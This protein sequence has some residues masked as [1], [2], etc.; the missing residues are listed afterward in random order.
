MEV[1]LV[2]YERLAAITQYENHRGVIEIE[3]KEGDDPNAAM[4]FAKQFL[5]HHLGVPVTPPLLREPS[6]Q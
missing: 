3:L 2:R 6:E 1:K 4:E 5:S